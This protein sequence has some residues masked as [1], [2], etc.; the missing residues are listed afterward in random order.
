M[1]YYIV[2]CKVTEMVILETELIDQASDLCDNNSNYEMFTRYELPY[3]II[4][5]VIDGGGSINA[6]LKNGHCTRKE[7][8]VIE[9]M[10][11]SHACAGVNIDSK[12][13]I[14]GLSTTLE[15][16]ANGL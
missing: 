1:T 4:V 2:V 13:Y 16:L 6:N 15:G 9:R 12:E 11:L 10:I 7:S 3:G 14:E 8:E 5:T